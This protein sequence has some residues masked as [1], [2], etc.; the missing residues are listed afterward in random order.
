MKKINTPDLQKYKPHSLKHNPQNNI[1]WLSH[2]VLNILHLN[3]L[4]NH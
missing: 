1:Y 3:K 2:V 4:L